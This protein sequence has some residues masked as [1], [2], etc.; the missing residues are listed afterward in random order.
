[1][2]VGMNRQPRIATKAQL[3]FRTVHRHCMTD[4]LGPGM[5]SDFNGQRMT[6]LT[7]R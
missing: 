2:T 4:W 6:A 7:D 3:E 5:A 1:M